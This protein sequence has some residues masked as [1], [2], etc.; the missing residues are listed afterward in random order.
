MNFVL[1]ATCKQTI[2]RICG[3][4]DSWLTGVKPQH[5]NDKMEYMEKMLAALV[6]VPAVPAN[7]ADE[8]PRE[9]AHVDAVP[10]PTS[11]TRIE[12]QNVQA[13]SGAEKLQTTKL[14]VL[15]QVLDLRDPSMTLR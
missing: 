4:V 13:L 7:I 1:D 2:D 9:S 8:A 12:G 11:R 6:A 3:T 10:I 5:L 14:K 15:V